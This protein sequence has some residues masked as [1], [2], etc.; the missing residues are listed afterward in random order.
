MFLGLVEYDS[1]YEWSRM[2]F[3]RNPLIREHH[4]RAVIY[5]DDMMIVIDQLRCLFSRANGNSLVRV[6]LVIRSGHVGS[7]LQANSLW[8]KDLAS[9]NLH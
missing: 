2:V 4:T 7:I 3:D 9:A 1:Q 6:D 5:K 8:K